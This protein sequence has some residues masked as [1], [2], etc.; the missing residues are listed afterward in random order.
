MATGGGF[1]VA[2]REIRT[3]HLQLIENTKETTPI[4]NNP[5]REKVINW[6]DVR[7]GFVRPLDSDSKTFVGKMDSYEEIVGDL[8]NAAKL[9]GMTSKTEI[10]GIADGGIGLSE[11]MKRQFPKMQFVLDKSHLEGHFYETAE[12]IGIPEK[13]RPRWVKNQIAVRPGKVAYFSGCESRPGRLASHR[14]ASP[15]IDGSNP[16]D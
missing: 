6:R 8:Y 10:I 3:G 15:W 9:I 2:A 7:L 16:R 13:K 11:E 5:K 4:Y 12:K 1:W 14:V